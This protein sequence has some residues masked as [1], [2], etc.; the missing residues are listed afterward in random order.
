M[1]NYMS[2]YREKQ[3]KKAE[4][5]HACK[6]NSKVNNDVNKEVNSK[7]NESANS[8]NSQVNSKPN[9]KHD[10]NCAEED[11][12]KEDKEGYKQEQDIDLGLDK[13]LDKEKDLEKRKYKRKEVYF[14]DEKL[15]DTF[16][17][18]IEM[19]KKIRSPM[20]E[21]AITIFLNKLKKLADRNGHFDNDLAIEIIEQSIVNDWKSIYPLTDKQKRGNSQRDLMQELYDA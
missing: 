1:K 14:P 8:V 15:N 5:K 11:I 12:Y 10:V 17:D 2:E 20:T 4:C 7:L 16:L 21:R 19:R 9:S 13:D 6:P 3:K 18:Y